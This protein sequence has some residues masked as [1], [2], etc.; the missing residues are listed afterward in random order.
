MYLSAP[1]ALETVSSNSTEQHYLPSVNENPIDCVK[2][3]LNPFEIDNAREARISY[4]SEL[5]P[6]KKPYSLEHAQTLIEIKSIRSRP[7]CSNQFTVASCGGIILSGVFAAVSCAGAY[8]AARQMDA[9]IAFAMFFAGTANALGNIIMYRDSRNQSHVADL[10]Q[11]LY[12][13]LCEEYAI[14]AKRMLE[15]HYVYHSKTAT[16]DKSWVETASKVQSKCEDILRN[17]EEIFTERVLN[18]SEIV[19]PLFDA[20]HHIVSQKPLYRADLRDFIRTW[21]QESESNTSML[22]LSTSEALLHALV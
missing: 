6:S 14:L 7:L 17:F 5:D 2:K 1:K 4:L 22:P 18:P 15:H 11:D 16:I 8:F 21:R 20:A 10:K 19:A 9:S 12:R 3:G 13:R